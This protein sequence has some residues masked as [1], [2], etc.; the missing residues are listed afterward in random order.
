MSVC[1]KFENKDYT[2]LYLTLLRPGI[3]TST[4]DKFKNRI[5]LS[6]YCEDKNEDKVTQ[7]P[8]QSMMVD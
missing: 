5:Y 7:P 6:I 1:Y 4:T 3:N 2:P 8:I